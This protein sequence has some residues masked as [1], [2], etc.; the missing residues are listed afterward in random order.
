MDMVIT[1]TKAVGTE[2][3][4]Y[5]NDQGSNKN[6]APNVPSGLTVSD[7]GQGKIVLKWK[8]PADDHTPT[9]SL[10]YMIRL[11]TKPGAGDLSTLPI[12]TAGRLQT[13]TFPVI[14][15]NEYYT[16]LPP[17]QYYWSVMAIDGNFKNSKFSEEQSFILKYPWKYINQGGLVDRRISPIENSQFA[18]ADFNNDG[19][20][21]FIYLG[22]SGVWG[23]SPAGIYKNNAGSFIKVENTNGNG[24]SGL[25]GIDNVKNLSIKCKDVN[26]D[27]YV[28]LFVAGEYNDN[29]PFFRS[30]INKRGFAFQDVSNLFNISDPLRTP[31][32]DFS[33]FDNNGTPDMIYS[34]TD[35]RGVGQVLFYTTKLDTL[36]VQGAANPNGFTIS[37]YET[38]IK[39]VLNDEEAQNINLAFSDFNQDKR[40]DM[41]MLYDNA[42]G[43]RKA[44]VFNGGLDEFGKGT[45]TKNTDVVLPKVKNS[46]LDVVDFNKDGYPD[47]AMSGYSSANGQMFKIY[48]NKFDKQTGKYTFSNTTNDLLLPIQDGKT[49]W[50]DFNMDG[51]PD[52]IFSG[53][54]T[55]AGYVTKMATS[56][57]SNN[58]VVSYTELP[59]FP[60]GDYLQLTPTMG[61]IMGD[62]QLGAVLVGR[63]TITGGSVINAFKLLQNVRGLSSKIEG[64][65]GIVQGK[66]SIPFTPLNTANKNAS[67]SGA[68]SKLKPSF[69]IQSAAFKM[70]ESLAQQ[71]QENDNQ[72]FV[73]NLPPNAP[74]SLTSTIL[75]KVGNLNLVKL[76][77]VPGKDDL[78]PDAGLTFSL[79]VGKKPGKSDVIDAEA[80]LG[81][82]RKTPTGGNTE[83]NT[84]WDIQL[85]NGTYYWSV[86][87]VDASFAGSAFA[88]EATLIIQND[89]IVAGSAPSDILL[90][91]T[92]KDTMYLA[93][94]QLFSTVK[95][96]L[97]TYSVDSAVV[98]KYNYSL[99]DDDDFTNPAIFG[100]DTSINN[101]YLKSSYQ[102][103]STY[104]VRVRVT[105][106]RGL[107]YDKLIAFVVVAA[108][109]NLLLDG[110]TTSFVNYATA[111]DAEQL[112]VT[113]TGVDDRISSDRL[114]YS[115]VDGTGSENNSMF[116]I[117]NNNILYNKV[118]LKLADTLR[119]RVAVSN[120]FA[121]LE[122]AI[123][124]YAGCEFKSVK[125]T[126]SKTEAY[127][128]CE[129]DVVNLTLA[130]TAATVNIF[131]DDALLSTASNT[132]KVSLTT[133][134]KY[135]AIY[136]VDA[137][138]ACGNRT[139]S[140]FV[141]YS[142]PVT[143]ITYN[144]NLT[145][146]SNEEKQLIAT[147]ATGYK[148]QWYKNDQIVTGS[149]GSTINAKDAGK[150]KVKIT[151]S[152]N[153][154]ATSKEV[155]LNVVQAADAT[156]S[157]KIDTTICEG[158]ALQI[159]V[160]DGPNS[161]QWF[162]NGNPE[163]VNSNTY[164]FTG[165]GQISVRI[166]S[167]NGCVANSQTRNI[168][169]TANPVAPVLTQ[170]A[171]ALCQGQSVVIM[172]QV[173][174]GVSY[175]WLKDGSKING[176]TEVNYSAT[177]TGNY[178]L[179]LTNQFGCT[180][181]SAN[182]TISSKP[183]PAAPSVSRD[184]SDLVSSSTQGNQWYNS[185]GE[186]IPGAT[187][188]KFRPTT[189]GYY[190]VKTTIN[191][192]TSMS[193]ANYFYVSTAVLNL[194]NGQFIK[195]F[196]NPVINGM[197]IEYNIQGQ[198]EMNIQLFDMTGKLILERKGLRTGNIVNLST[199]TKGTYMLKVMKKD[200]K[201]LYSGKIA[202]Q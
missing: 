154:S 89:A 62:G 69:E 165:N 58:N 102:K 77:W 163:Q 193:S 36:I 44:E 48:Q 90:N 160:A 182:A 37:T 127:K 152:Q 96:K 170:T 5:V 148:Y 55:G 197:T 28:D 135:Y 71:A 196:P 72:Q 54:R 178:Q 2:T 141:E 31:A 70:L 34:G 185:A 200:G 149:I 73:E 91:G 140:V 162:R 43:Q 60:F 171:T 95:Y 27:G 19:L 125:F 92:S 64:E 201:V 59:S 173:I 49:T 146:C 191:G 61:D 195:L 76:A 119:V 116:G 80:N 189:N 192:C 12:D 172:G 124:I 194:S 175:Q 105:D 4:I 117:K 30:F 29:R 111:K 41:V 84:Q 51:Y 74:T 139:D 24:F 183:I 130:S 103:D 128:I 21:D 99:Y 75:Q 66:V 81:G 150:Y 115:F 7:Q 50:G 104:N 15:T 16:E 85:P 94:N 138:S 14:G 109:N 176:A 68:K 23:Q 142:V 168:T 181:L 112:S 26:N 38:N 86:Q 9:R 187:T 118:P 199:L 101:L 156:L 120:G 167:S 11:G 39:K 32:I 88:P 143:E 87:A 45:F 159:K 52:V 40:V 174:G 113:M 158:T 202:K 18:W 63:E 78:T 42:S 8:A 126:D 137:N 35:S 155:V 6:T 20:T 57:L 186:A 47:I 134:G 151:N 121:S 147:A 164:N 107:A 177:N 184:A 114:T 10:S 65:N 129:G 1:G 46:T 133:P 100:I 110:A 106:S 136:N 198:S 161:Y 33:D 22:N 132:N 122:K 53:T 56:A 190:T 13:P 108:P 98:T 145:I 82:D 179:Q 123:K 3:V 144:G 97:T 83:N 17:G 79:R 67:V 153:C 25:N 188:Q 93:Q 180:S 131:K 169:T 157:Q 166:T